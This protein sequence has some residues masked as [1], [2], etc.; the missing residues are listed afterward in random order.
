M[1]SESPTNKPT[2]AGYAHIRRLPPHKYYVIGHYSCHECY[3]LKQQERKVI[4]EKQAYSS[5]HLVG[6]LPPFAELPPLEACEISLSL[7]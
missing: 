4:T 1:S 2:E 5:H 7:Q 3:D 6:E